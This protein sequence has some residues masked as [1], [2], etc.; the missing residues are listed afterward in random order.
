MAQKKKDA[1]Q[2]KG[3]TPTI[4]PTPIQRVASPE[5]QAAIQARAQRA[6][7]EVAV[8]KQR[9]AETEVAKTIAEAEREQLVQQTQFLQQRITALEKEVNALKNPKDEAENPDAPPESEES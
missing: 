7:T 3:Q 9:F 5:E 2:E 1:P 6:R 8:L 4:T